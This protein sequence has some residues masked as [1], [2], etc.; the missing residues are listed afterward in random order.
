MDYKKV[1]EMLP[2]YDYAPTLNRETMPF[3]TTVITEHD[4]DLQHLIFAPD[5]ETGFPSS[6]LPLNLQKSMENDVREYVN[7]YLQPQNG[8]SLGVEDVKEEP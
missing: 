8:Y 1:I 7:K 6:Q 4:D 2:A 3:C 5:P